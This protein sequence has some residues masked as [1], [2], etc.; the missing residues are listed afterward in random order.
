MVIPFYSWETEVQNPRL[1]QEKPLHEIAQTT[2]REAHTATETQHCQT[3]INNKFIFKDF[4]IKE[5]KKKKKDFV[6]LLSFF[7]NCDSC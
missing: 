7:F 2:T 4:V 3:Q 6:S 1:Q 5:E